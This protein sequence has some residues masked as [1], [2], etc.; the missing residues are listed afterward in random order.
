MTSKPPHRYNDYLKYAVTTLLLLYFLL[1]DLPWGV[2]FFFT[3]VFLVLSICKARY[4]KLEGR[5]QGLAYFFIVVSAIYVIM[6]G[7]ETI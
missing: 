2:Y 4:D 6:S 7:Y 5:P 3:T 1:R